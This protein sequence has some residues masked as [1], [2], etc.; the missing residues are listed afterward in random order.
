MIDE[1]GASRTTV[2]VVEDIGW[3]RERMKQSLALYDYLVLEASDDEEAI[4]IASRIHPDLI[5]TEEELDTFDALAL[6]L[7]QH[8][9]LCH[10]PVV[11]VNPDVEE[12]ILYGDINM[13]PDYDGIGRLLAAFRSQS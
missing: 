3:I 4:E 1:A 6:R 13:L 7:R 5:L 2:L 9:A 11:I 10:I 12:G 8:P